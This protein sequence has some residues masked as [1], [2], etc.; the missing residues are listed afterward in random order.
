MVDTKT[1]WFSNFID[2]IK[3]SIK[4]FKFFKNDLEGQE[5]PG[6]NT[7]CNKRM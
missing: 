1:M 2:L 5:I 4:V 6:W 7:E 3:Q